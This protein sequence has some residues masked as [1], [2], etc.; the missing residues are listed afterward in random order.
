MWQPNFFTSHMQLIR[1]IRT[2]SP[3]TCRLD[4]ATHIFSRATC[5]SYV[6]SE[7]FR[8]PHATCMW[9]LNFF[10]YHMQPVC[11]FRT[12]HFS[13]AAKMWHPNFFACHIQ[14]ICSIRTFSRATYSKNV[15]TDFSSS[16]TYSQSVVIEL[17]F[18]AHGAKM[19]QSTFFQ[20]PHPTRMWQYKNSVATY[21]LYVAND[22]WKRR[23]A[24]R[25]VVKMMSMENQW[26][27]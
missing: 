4:V 12:F 16:P 11:G 23:F 22:K 17:F 14:L 8:V 26:T 10:A 27:S 13:H 9:H 7:L 18:A 5:S 19:W 20:M 25:G 21:E 2:F 24:A 15:V 6:A 3:F 1:S